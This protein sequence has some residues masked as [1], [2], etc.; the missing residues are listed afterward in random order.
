MKTIEISTEADYKRTLSDVGSY[1]KPSILILTGEQS[2]HKREFVKALEEK[3][4]PGEEGKD[5]NYGAFYA[6]D[7]ETSFDSAIESCYTAPFGTGKRLVL[8]QHYNMNKETDNIKKYASNPS[9]TAL[10]VLTADIAV[11][12][13]PLL[14]SKKDEFSDTIVLI[15]SPPSKANMGIW[16]K[17]F[18][19]SKGQTITRDAV[20]YLLDCVRNAEEIESVA[21]KASA[22]HSDKQVLDIKEISDFAQ[23]SKIDVMFEFSDAVLGRNSMRALTLFSRLGDEFMKTHS[24]LTNKFITL[25]FL[26][27][28]PGGVRNAKTKNIIK[29][30]PFALK[31]DAKFLGNF[32]TSELADILNELY[33]MNVCFVSQPKHI[34][35]A[36]FEAFLA[37][38]KR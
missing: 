13:D 1:T 32:S 18:F 36:R 35:K 11:K 25:Y 19:E 30:H 34:Q 24:F 26:S 5:W 29:A 17:K 14:K 37:S 7:D 28:I 38:L 22:F 6:K 21:A 16:V 20:E 33:D 2:A 15:F 12:D 4:F 27:I 31:N 3:M 8:Y 9:K 10:L 23:T